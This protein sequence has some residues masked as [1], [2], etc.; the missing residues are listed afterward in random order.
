MVNFVVVVVD[1]LLLRFALVNAQSCK[2]CNAVLGLI[3]SVRECC[4]KISIEANAGV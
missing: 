1:L 4:V 3:F 2:L